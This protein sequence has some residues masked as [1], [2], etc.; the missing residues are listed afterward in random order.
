[1]SHIDVPNV[2]SIPTPPR[3]SAA[4]FITLFFPL[5]AWVTFLARMWSRLRV[6]RCWALDDWLMVPAALCSV[7]MTPFFFLYIKLGYFGWRKEDVPASFNPS[8]G[9]Y[10]FYIAQIFYNPILAF[11]K[12]SILVFILHIGRRRKG[13]PW[14]VYSVITLT[15]LQALAVFLGVLLQC[16]PI[17]ANWDSTL[18][19]TAKCIDPSFH[20][21]ISSVTV[22]T[23]LMVLALPFYV[24]L[25]L[26]VGL[27]P[28]TTS[29]SP[30]P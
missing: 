29:K 4:L 20:V 15:V 9:L 28:S 26:Q 17:A 5:L 8:A 10:F 24:F 25:G 21:T 27:I 14:M 2:S 12:C 18:R 3:Q 11:V 30:T 13:V 22:L 19:P 1:M 6:T 16:L 7:L 23:D